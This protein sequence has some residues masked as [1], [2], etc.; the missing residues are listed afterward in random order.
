MHSAE[1]YDQLLADLR[2]HGHPRKFARVTIRTDDGPLRWVIPRREAREY[3]YEASLGLVEVE[4][5]YG[6]PRAR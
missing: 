3:L 4:M 1:H 2:A 5:H 6:G